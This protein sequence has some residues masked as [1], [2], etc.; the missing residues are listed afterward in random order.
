M[1][2]MDKGPV[3]RRQVVGG[4]GAGLVAAAAPAFAQSAV[5]P[6]EPI[7]MHDPTTKY[8]KPPFKQQSQPCPAS[9]AKWIRG[10]TMA[11]RAIVVPAGSPD[12]RR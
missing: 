10:P 6:A 2:L 5:L 9:Q 12:E 1:D 4:A 7:P 3:L 8:P 11:R